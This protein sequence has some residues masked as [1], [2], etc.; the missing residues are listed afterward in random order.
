MGYDHSRNGGQAARILPTTQSTHVAIKEEPTRTAKIT[1]PLKVSQATTIVKQEGSPVTRKI[2]D[3]LKEA[4]VPRV[5]GP[6]V[7]SMVNRVPTL[8]EVA[9]RAVIVDTH[10]ANSISPHTST[11][12]S[13]AP[14]RITISSSP[15]SVNGSTANAQRPSKAFPYPNHDLTPNTLGTSRSLLPVTPFDTPAGLPLLVNPL[16]C[17]QAIKDRAESTPVQPPKPNPLQRRRIGPN[18]EYLEWH[19]SAK[20]PA[21]KK[22]PRSASVNNVAKQGDPSLPWPQP[23]PVKELARKAVNNSLSNL[24]SRQVH[25]QLRNGMNNPT[26]GNQSERADKVSTTTTNAP[27]RII[28]H[29]AHRGTKRS[30]PD[31]TTVSQRANTI[32][33]DKDT[34]SMTSETSAQSNKHTKKRKSKSTQSHTKKNRKIVVPSSDPLSQPEFRTLTVLSLA[35]EVRT[36]EAKVSQH[37]SS[38]LPEQT[39]AAACFT[40]SSSDNDEEP[41]EELLLNELPQLEQLRQGL[42]KIDRPSEPENGQ[43]TL[44]TAQ[45]A[46]KRMTENM[47]LMSQPKTSPNVSAPQKSFTPPPIAAAPIPPAQ[48]PLDPD[49]VIEQISCPICGCKYDDIPALQVHLNRHL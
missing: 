21:T 46:I 24:T 16:A 23:A 20:T 44:M 12:E 13:N 6:V 36:L 10:S 22:R 39:D 26:V 31:T 38:P 28:S 7:P 34:V 32:T 15:E 30:S 45:M 19:V 25:L 37:D 1:P 4:G 49:G 14:I 11:A 42:F 8:S 17:N 9:G 41:Y 18:Y 3:I 29:N 5:N 48:P 2:A 35:E 27:N 40:I 43:K 47:I 33:W